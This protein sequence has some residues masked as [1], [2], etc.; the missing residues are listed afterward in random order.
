[1]KFKLLTPKKK[2]KD[3][4]VKLSLDLEVC[5]LTDLMFIGMDEK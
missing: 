3:L 4:D 2:K 5:T 1:M